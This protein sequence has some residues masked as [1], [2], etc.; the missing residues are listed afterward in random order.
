MPQAISYTASVFLVLENPEPKTGIGG[1]PGRRT[2]TMTVIV[3][4]GIYAVCLT[5]GWYANKKFATFL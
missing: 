3:G 1:L 2:K 4:I 5:L